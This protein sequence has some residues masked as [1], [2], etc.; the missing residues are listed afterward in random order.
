M[1]EGMT[2]QMI[3]L[4]RAFER[5]ELAKANQWHIPDAH[6]DLAPASDAGLIVEVLRAIH[7]SD[8]LN[9]YPYDFETSIVNALHHATSLEE[10]LLQQLPTNELNTYLKRVEQSCV[11]CHNAFRH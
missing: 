7:L 9:E 1:P 4:N 2:K 3:A 11:H 5:L 8:E 10:A 6:P